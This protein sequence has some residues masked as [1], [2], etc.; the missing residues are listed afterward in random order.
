MSLAPAVATIH[1]MQRLGLVERAVEL[2]PY[3]EQKLQALKA[4]HPCVGDVR[5]KG[6]F[7]AV[8]L[9]KNQATKQPFNTYMEK[10]AGV[11]LLVDQIAGKCMADGVI[12]QAW[13]S[14]FVIAPPLI[15]TTAEL[16]RGI[17]TLDKH[18]S[19][20]DAFVETDALVE[21]TAAR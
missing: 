20:A 12:I 21:L 8:E 15:V 5:G 11:P 13:V 10:I 17:D 7:W 14:H 1:E 6:L 3:V 4:K 9:V 2:A 16:D 18:L 19:I